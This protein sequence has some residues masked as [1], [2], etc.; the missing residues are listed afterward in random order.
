VRAR[1]LSRSDSSQPWQL[2]HQGLFYDLEREGHRL[3]SEPVKLSPLG[4]SMWRLEVEQSG[5]GLGSGIPQLE[6]TWHP[7]RLLFIARGEMPFTLAFGPQQTE[8][9]KVTIDPLLRRI[10]GGGA[11]AGL[12]KSAA[13]GERFELGGEARL[14]PPT[15]PLPWQK[16]LLWAVLL[17]GVT[18]LALM[19]RSLYRQMVR[20]GASR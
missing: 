4:H 8:A 3:R 5:G 6:V 13:A 1:L 12:I 14:K 2:R 10:N 9:Q 16:W 15:P 18:V 20:E 7:Q 11:S 19:V 17:L